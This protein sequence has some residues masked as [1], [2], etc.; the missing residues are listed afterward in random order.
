[1]DN[2][3]QYYIQY[4]S[5]WFYH[6]VLYTDT[7]SALLKLIVFVVLLTLL[8]YQKYNY[9]AIGIVTVICVLVFLFLRTSSPAAFAFATT[10]STGPRF[11]D[12]D[13]LTTGVP[14]IKEGFG[15]AMPKI[16]QGDDSG[17][18]YHRSNKFIEEDSRDFTEKYFN[19]K[20]CGIGSGIGGISMFGSNEL[21][22]MSRSVVLS[23]LYNFDKY[24]VTN[25]DDTVTFN[26]DNNLSRNC[27]SKCK[28]GRRW[29]Y[30]NDCVFGPIQRND[31]RVLKKNIYENVNNNIINI[32]GV[33][34]RVDKTILFN[35]QNDP[36]ADYSKRV[37]LSSQT[38]SELLEKPYNYI[39][40]IN[41]STNTEKLK[42]IQTL[43]NG[44]NINDRQYSE[45]LSKINNN[46]DMNSS[47]KQRHLEIYAKV[48]EFRKKLDSIFANMRAQ[49]K[50]DASF[51]YTIRVGEPVVQEMRMML[52]YLA[53][54]QRTNDIILFEENVGKDN[55]GIYSMK[56]TTTSSLLALI[57]PDDKE[58]KYKSQIIGSLNNIFKI[59]LEDD[60][61]NNNDEKRYLYG[62]TYYFDKA[63][64]NSNPIG[65]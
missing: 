53:M 34:N 32:N 15:I 25:N 3:I 40:L 20:K 38:N 18:D 7:T 9:F 58:G 30:F 8:V 14:L 65:T 12:K 59:P 39:S 49:T 57:L 21:I 24:Y 50:D 31:F 43:S 2:N 11:V 26:D 37:S 60:S 35:T 4:I 54:I 33:L 62:I 29:T 46:R 19:S 28:E 6:N 42:N 47:D 61:Y 48:Y 13:E 45:L 64:S 22:D 44:D 17:K 5:S 10:T 16:I 63:N 56:P 51:M 27:D 55:N 41:G 23:G 52:S 1:M 36:G